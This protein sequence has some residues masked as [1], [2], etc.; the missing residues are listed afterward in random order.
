MRKIFLH[1]FNHTNTKVTPFMSNPKVNPFWHDISELCFSTGGWVG[2]TVAQNIALLAPEA[3]YLITPL[4][5]LALYTVL[6]A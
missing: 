5:L 1:F 4:V 6:P 2:G 3:T